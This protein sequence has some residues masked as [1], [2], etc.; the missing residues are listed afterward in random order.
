MTSKRFLKTITAA[1]LVLPM[2]GGIA[3]AYELVISS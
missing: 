3:K 2:M 1:L